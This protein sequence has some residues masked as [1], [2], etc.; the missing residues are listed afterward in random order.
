[1]SVKGHHFCE[2]LKAIINDGDYPLF[3]LTLEQITPLLDE[4]DNE[5]IQKTLLAHG[6]SSKSIEIRR[7][8]SRDEGITDLAALNIFKKIAND[9]FEGIDDD[10]ISESISA[11]GKCSLSAIFH[12]LHGNVGLESIDSNRNYSEKKSDIIIKI[13]RAISG[14]LTNL[15]SA[16]GYFGDKFIDRDISNKAMSSLVDFSKK[17]NQIQKD[18]VNKLFSKIS[19]VRYR[20]DVKI[21]ASEVPKF[22]SGVLLNPEL[23]VS[24]LKGGRENS[25]LPVLVKEN[26]DFKYARSE[27]ISNGNIVFRKNESEPTGLRDELFINSR[28][29]CDYSFYSIAEKCLEIG[30]SIPL[31]YKLCMALASDLAEMPLGRIDDALLSKTDALT[32]SA[33]VNP[34]LPLYYHKGNEDEVIQVRALIQI[35][36]KNDAALAEFKNSQRAT[37]EFITSMANSLADITP[38]VSKTSQYTDFDTCVEYLAWIKSEFN[39]QPES[40]SV[41][42]TDS[43]HI[44]LM[45]AAGV[46]FN[47]KYKVSNLAGKSITNSLNMTDYIAIVDMGGNFNAKEIPKTLDEALRMASRRTNQPIYTALL[48]RFQFEDLLGICKND[49]EYGALHQAFPE[50]SAELVNVA[51]HSVKRRII[52][53]DMDI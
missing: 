18:E 43:K 1:M 14:D 48:R 22:D 25:L 31:G 27:R 3:K 8:C 24:Y 45:H 42:F 32:E 20:S 13:I 49:S 9:G 52:S 12:L 41:F 44:K 15:E 26:A 11:V 17:L 6:P 40:G 28:A 34:S 29:I 39:I 51:P 4:S 7:H 47:D 19:Q 35:L 2:F 16:S 50:R 23:L 10:T 53:H 37:P 21:S 30:I 33:W 46:R 38:S 36:G 5:K